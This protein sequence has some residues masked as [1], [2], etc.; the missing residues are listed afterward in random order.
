[1]LSN[2][3]DLDLRLIRVFLAVVNA[4]GITAAEATLGVRQSTISTQLL[5]LEARVGFRLCERGRGGFRLTSK[6]ERFVPSARALIAATSE[7]VERLREIDRKLVG[8]LAIGV[9]GQASHIESA[10][11][12]QAL[13]AFRKHDQA[14]RFTMKVVAPQELEDS[15]VNNRLD[16]AIGYFWRRVAG[17]DYTELFS[18]RQELY[19]GRGH[20]LFHKAPHVNIDGLREQDW[21]WRSYPIPEE[22]AGIGDRQV[23]ARA[24]SIDAATVLI[25]SGSHIG[26]LPAVHAEPFEQRGLVR[27]LGRATFGYDVAMHVAIKR[28]ASENPIVRT[29]CDE[30]LNVYGRHAATPADSPAPLSASYQRHCAGV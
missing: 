25:L 10:R 23:T 7:F 27:A 21:V 15:L 30:L 1:M 24:D 17:L 11:L 12:A 20:A 13:G 28:G 4:R 8:T 9:I 6:G 3:S 22:F 14:V 26:Y 19:C 16:I 5:A 18:E 2:T 29:F